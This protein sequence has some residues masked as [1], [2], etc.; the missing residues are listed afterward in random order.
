MIGPKQ[1]ISAG[2]H[3]LQMHV[4]VLHY[5]SGW[6]S[7]D[8]SQAVGCDEKSGLSLGQTDRSAA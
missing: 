7:A 5:K 2:M 8:I 1:S 4:G 3:E 6:L